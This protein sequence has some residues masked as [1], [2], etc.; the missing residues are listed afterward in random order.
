MREPY[1]DFY[2]DLVMIGMLYAGIF[3]LIWFLKGWLT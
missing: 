3:F 2:A 1:F